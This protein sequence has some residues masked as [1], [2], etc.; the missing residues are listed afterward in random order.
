MSLDEFLLTL[1][2]LG[3]IKKDSTHYSLRNCHLHIHKRNIYTISIYLG[4]LTQVFHGEDCFNQALK[5][6]TRKLKNDRKGN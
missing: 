5:S 2:V 6:I 1:H 3:F 4:G